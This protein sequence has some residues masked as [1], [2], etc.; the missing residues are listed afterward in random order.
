M[1]AG[2]LSALNDPYTKVFHESQQCSELVLI[3]I[4]FFGW[5]V[6]A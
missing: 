1:A 2:V 6:V 4:S 5:L 3:P